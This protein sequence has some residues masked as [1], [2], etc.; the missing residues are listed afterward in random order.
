MTIYRI[1]SPRAA[2][3]GHVGAV[4]FCGGIGSTSS[5]TDAVALLELGRGFKLIGLSEEEKA[6]VRK[7]RAALRKGRAER[8]ADFQKLD[9]YERTPEGVAHLL[10]KKQEREREAAKQQPRLRKIHR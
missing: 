8:L 9:A 7:F 5:L 3:E 4:D 6:E 2:F 1:R 10:E